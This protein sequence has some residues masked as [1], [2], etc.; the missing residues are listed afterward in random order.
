MG[1]GNALQNGNKDVLEEAAV[2]P[3]ARVMNPTQSKRQSM[4]CI[5]KAHGSTRKRLESTLPERS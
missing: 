3:S 4:H 2:K 1:A 5:V